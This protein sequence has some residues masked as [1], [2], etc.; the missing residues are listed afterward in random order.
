[1]NGNTI[2]PAIKIILGEIN[3]KLA[4]AA[5][6]AKAAYACA[7]TGAIEEGVIVSMDIEHLL[8]EAGRLGD[9][10]SL[11]SLLADEQSRR[12]IG[13]RHPG[14]EQARRL[15][16][17]RPKLD[18]PR[19]YFWPNDEF[20]VASTTWAGLIAP[21]LALFPE[22]SNASGTLSNPCRTCEIVGSSATRLEET[23][24][25]AY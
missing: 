6:V 15:K 22:I 16:R 9:A 23:R 13:D 11:L 3:S 14:I 7:E 18:R 25:I 17:A 8:Y 1:M 10:A 5:R 21:Y 19:H 12:L 24:S 20:Q 2:E 4:E